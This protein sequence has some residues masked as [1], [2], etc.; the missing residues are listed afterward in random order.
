M[1]CRKC[2]CFFPNSERICPVC[3][4]D[5]AESK[6]GNYTSLA[7]GLFVIFLIGCYFNP[8]V[9]LVFMLFISVPCI[10]LTN[11]EY[12][13]ASKNNGF[14]FTAKT[15]KFKEKNKLNDSVKKIFLT[16]DAATSTAEI[17]SDSQIDTLRDFNSNLTTVWTDADSDCSILIEFSY[18]GFGGGTSWRNIIVTEASINMYSELYFIGY[19][20]D[21]SAERTFKVERINSEI[22]FNGKKYS[23]EK[24]IDDVLFL[25][26][27][28]FS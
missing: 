25:D 16:R 19:C 22:K 28:E 20:L 3:K 13:Q 8:G 17:P 2:D 11:N 24:F 4:N 5:K 21:K 23:K 1:H 7:L 15:L 26:S 10:L 27:S 6:L 9:S 14:L 18:S 12:R